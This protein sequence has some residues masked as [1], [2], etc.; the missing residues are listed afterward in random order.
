MTDRPTFDETYPRYEFAELVRLGIAIGKTFQR[1]VE[2][3]R[4]MSTLRKAATVAGATI[5]VAG[6][7]MPVWADDNTHAKFAQAKDRATTEAHL[8]GPVVLTETE[9]DAVTAGAPSANPKH[10]V[11]VGSKIKEVVKEASTSKYIE[12]LS[13]SYKAVLF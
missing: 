12:R 3:E 5:L 6:L 10:I 8:A 4:T 13:N 11:V 9:M 1:C 7:A 2:R